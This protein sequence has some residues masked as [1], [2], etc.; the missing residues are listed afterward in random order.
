MY[1][2][3]SFCGDRQVVTWFKGPDF[4]HAVDSAQK[5]RA[6]EAYLACSVCLAIIEADDRE[7]LAA[8]ELIRQRGKGG[9]KPGVTE[10]DVIRIKHSILE[11]TFWSARVE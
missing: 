7:G 11:G 4:R 5:V 2:V 9:L 1:P 6:D 3:C 10:Q 8:R